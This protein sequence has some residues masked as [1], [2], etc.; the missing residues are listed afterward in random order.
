MTVS[1]SDVIASEIHWAFCPGGQDID[2]YIEFSES[3]LCH[4]NFTAACGIEMF[5]PCEWG[6][7]ESYTFVAFLVG[8]VYS[9]PLTVD[10]PLFYTPAAPTTSRP[11]V[12]PSFRPSAPPSY[13]PFTSTTTTSSKFFIP[14]LVYKKRY[15]SK[16]LVTSFC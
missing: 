14:S 7:L 16:M 4:G 10:D 1:L 9:I 3:C 2:N 6:F 5:L 12:S 15:K 13:Q 8:A 11:S